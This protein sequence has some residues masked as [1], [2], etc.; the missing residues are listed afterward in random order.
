MFAVSNSYLVTMAWIGGSCSCSQLL[1]ELGDM[2]M[3]QWN[4]DAAAARDPFVA[5]S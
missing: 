1:G 3:E 2:L 4:V 5:P